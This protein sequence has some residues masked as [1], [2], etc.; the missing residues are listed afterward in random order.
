[1]RTDHDSATKAQWLAGARLRTLPLAV[2]PVAIGTGAAIGLEGFEPVR[3]VLALV[4]ALALQVGVNYAN[5][6]SDGIRGTDDERVG[7]FRLTGS[8][9]AAPAAVRSAAFAAFGVAAVTGLALTALSGSWWLLLVG[10]ACVLAAWYYTGGAHPYGYAGLG[11]VAVFI[12]FGLVAVLATTY[13]QAGSVSWGATAGAI[14]IGSLACAVLVVNNLRDIPGDV[15]SGKFTLAVRLGDPRTRSL[16][17]G[18][19]V[20]AYL[21]V[22]AIVFS[23]PWAALVL[24]TVPLSLRTA[25]VV[26]NGA[27]G[28]ALI[29]VL[30]DTGK[31]ALGYGI[32]LGLG[33]AGIG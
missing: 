19:L 14:G 28:A 8:G 32:L 20:V 27:F 1:M 13:T 17:L 26:G 5:D 22:L 6:Y 15:H 11:E 4:V 2:A 18:L 10:G 12:F 21:A 33:L 31:I 24:L 3:A 16:Y 7:P 25:R 30:R 9:A 23:S 29:P